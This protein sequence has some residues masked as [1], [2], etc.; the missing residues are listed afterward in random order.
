MHVYP[1]SRSNAVD[2]AFGAELV[3]QESH[4]AAVH[5]EDRSRQLEMAMH[6]VQQEPI[7]AE[8][9][10]NV[11]VVRVRPLVAILDLSESYPRSLGTRADASDAQLGLAVDTHVHLLR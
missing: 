7:T 5:A 3:Q 2:Q 11:T 6:H 4:G 10:E 8:C 1:R 9:D